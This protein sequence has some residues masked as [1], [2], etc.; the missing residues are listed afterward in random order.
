MEATIDNDIENLKSTDPDIHDKA[1][2][3]LV[4][5]KS[6]AVPA[7]LNLLANK[8]ENGRMLAAAALAEIADSSSS[9]AVLKYTSDEDPRV[10]AWS[11]IALRKMNDPL[12]LHA[13]LATIDDYQD[14]L[15]NDQTLV[16]Y[17]LIQ[18][19][20]DVLLP[21]LNLLNAAARETRLHA[22]SVVKKIVFEK[23]GTKAAW[24]DAWIKNGAYTIDMDEYHRQQCIEKWK[25]WVGEN[26]QP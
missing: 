25:K 5:N 11:A 22:F 8:K 17:A 9:D 4:K 26:N 14:E 10:R 23:M 12:A 24:E 16:T 21:V 3:N 2:Q 1:F 13:L 18:W 15:H 6:A 19:G 7:L 20:E